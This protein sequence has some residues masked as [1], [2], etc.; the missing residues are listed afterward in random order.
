VTLRVNGEEITSAATG[1]GPVDAAVE[2]L[3]RSVQAVGEIELLEYHV[4]AISG[5]TDALVDVTVKMA[6]DGKIITSRGAR[7]DIITAS[8]EAVVAGMNRLLRD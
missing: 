4:D 6:K 2:A 3:R 8:V 1:T 7:T 5:G